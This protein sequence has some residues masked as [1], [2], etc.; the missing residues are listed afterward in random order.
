MDD[1]L[2]RLKKEIKEKRKKTVVPEPIKKKTNNFFYRYLT[3]FFIT[4][5]LML[6]TMI[7][8]KGNQK[9]KTLFYKHVFD[10]NISFATIN[11]LYSDY[12]GSPI[13]FQNLFKDKVK[14]VFNE[15][16]SYKEASKYKDGVKLTVENK[17]LVPVLE[18]GIV[19]FI[20]EK[21]GYGKTAIIQQVNGIDVWY[22]N[23]GNLSVSL[24][25]FV[26]KGTLLGEVENESLYLVFAKE[27]KYL[28]YQEFI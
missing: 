26:E 11:K 5:I 25:D 2:L 28:D 7:A 22:S 6:L 17:Y 13:P 1:E 14:P 10:T 23:I 21:E 8:I 3:K 20:G 19:I 12:F 4:V 16:L 15:N 27:G 18:T 9:F 24:Y